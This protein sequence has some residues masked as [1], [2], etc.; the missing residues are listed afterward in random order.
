MVIE[1]IQQYV[2]R[3]FANEILRSIR[4]DPVRHVDGASKVGYAAT[5]K[6][7]PT[8]IKVK[9]LGGYVRNLETR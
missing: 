5:Y 9:N 1:L 7:R 6:V 2:V 3:I 8:R 4:I